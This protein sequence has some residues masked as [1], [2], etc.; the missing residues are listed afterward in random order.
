MRTDTARAKGVTPYGTYVSIGKVRGIAK[1]PAL[2]G[3][4]NEYLLG[5]T[6]MILTDGGCM[7][8]DG[9]VEVRGGEIVK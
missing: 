3:D 7:G 4:C 5:E 8:L 1:L 6:M 9:W 2:A